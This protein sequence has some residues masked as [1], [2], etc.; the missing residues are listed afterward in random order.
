MRIDST[1]CVPVAPLKRGCLCTTAAICFKGAVKE[2]NTPR[3]LALVLVCY[4]GKR[5]VSKVCALI[6]MICKSHGEILKIEKL[7]VFLD[8]I[9]FSLQIP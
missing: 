2:R 4:P 1:G 8:K 5:V 6:N 3:A 7:A 9:S